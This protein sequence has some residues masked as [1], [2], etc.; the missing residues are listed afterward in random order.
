MHYIQ[1]RRFLGNAYR[2]VSVHTATNIQSTVTAKNAGRH[3]E[4]SESIFEGSQVIYWLRGTWPIY[5]IFLCRLW[6]ARGSVVGWVTM[7]KAGRS[8]FQVSMK[9]LDFLLISLIFP[10]QTLGST[11][12][13][14]EKSAK[15]F[16]REGNKERPVCK[17]DNLTAVCEPN[18]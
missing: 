11:Q 13:L 15:N 14:T 10:T 6:G 8:R 16:P 17:A 5:T 1:S 7:L 9:S 4:I 12:P 3:R 2:N 18:V